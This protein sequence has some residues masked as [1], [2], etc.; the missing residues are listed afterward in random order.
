MFIKFALT[1]VSFILISAQS[2]EP[3]AEASRLNTQVIKLFGEQKYD[4]A[5]PLAQQV[6]KIRESHLDADDERVAAAIIN[7]ATIYDRKR[8]YEEA[9]H[10]FE[11]VLGLCEK[12]FGPDDA[13]V[14]GVLDR[15]TVVYFNRWKFS[16]SRNAAERALAINEKKFGGEGVQV[17]NSLHR[18]AEFYRYRNPEK[19]EAYYDRALIIMRKTLPRDNEVMKKLVESYS[20][21]FYETDQ[22]EKLK[23]MG[24]RYWPDDLKKMSESPSSVLNGKAIKLPKPSFPRELRATNVSGRVVVKV[25]IDEQGKVI[26][27]RDMCGAHPSLAKASLAAAQKAEFTPTKLSGQPVKV[28]GVITYN[29]IRQ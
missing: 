27:A 12:K 19:A 18:V 11:R 25:W 22:M 28:Q 2:S 17:A 20:C 26:E 16:E 10:L 23:G 14:A 9:E 29:F 7:L 6:L 15:L 24:Q 5:I 13:R 1:F 4:E 21:L 3:L 8:K